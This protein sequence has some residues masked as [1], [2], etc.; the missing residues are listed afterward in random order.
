MGDNTTKNDKPKKVNFFHGIKRE[1]KKI[2]WPTAKDVT[3]QTVVVTI[4]TFVLAVLIGLIDLGL[5]Y[6]LRF[7]TGA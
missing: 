3:K 5:K 2:T 6:G 7:I 1:F 4:V